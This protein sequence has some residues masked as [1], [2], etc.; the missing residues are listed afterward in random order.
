MQKLG[1]LPAGAEALKT[2]SY[3]TQ[4]QRKPS[5]A[6]EHVEAEDAALKFA[7]VADTRHTGGKNKD[8]APNE[9][10]AYSMKAMLKR[11]YQSLS[12]RH[13]TCI[14][15]CNAESSA[16]VTRSSGVL[17]CTTPAKESALVPG[18]KDGSPP[19]RMSCPLI[20]P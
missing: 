14:Q 8:Y 13:D 1:S 19:W 11:I 16:Q 18:P 4:A 2:T 15:G 7:K 3:A 9:N 6:S 17:F 12:S 5:I 20:R 10:I